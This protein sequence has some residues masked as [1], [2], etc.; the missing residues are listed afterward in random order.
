M[1]LLCKNVGR[2]PKISQEP[3]VPKGYS[4]VLLQDTY[5]LGKAKQCDL[6]TQ[7]TF[8]NNDFG[9]LS[10]IYRTNHFHMIKLLSRILR[11]DVL[12]LFG[13]G[14]R[15]ETLTVGSTLIDWQTVLTRF[16]FAQVRYGLGKV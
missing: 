14:Y 16:N 12:K 8:Y 2:T 10:Q 5:Y 3:R 13:K 4:Y 11:S 6:I 7:I 1:P 9:K 15:Y